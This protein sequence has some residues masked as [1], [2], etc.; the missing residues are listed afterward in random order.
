MQSDIERKWDFQ[1]QFLFL[2]DCM[3][4]L[5]RVSLNWTDLIPWKMDQLMYFIVIYRSALQCNEIQEDTEQN[6]FYWW[7]FCQLLY[8]TIVFIFS[9]DHVQT[10][11]NIAL[12]MFSCHIFIIRNTWPQPRD[13]AEM[14]HGPRWRDVWHKNEKSCVLFYPSKKDKL[15]NLY[16]QFLIWDSTITNIETHFN[17]KAC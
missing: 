6:N 7:F 10:W 17:F 8:H 13:A 1:K 4:F 2:C 9:F 16:P 15:Q 11:V 12:Y 3:N 14:A 5:H